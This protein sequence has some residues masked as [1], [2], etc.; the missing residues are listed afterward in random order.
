MSKLVIL[1]KDPFDVRQK[2]FSIGGVQT[3]IKNLAELARNN[4]YEVIVCE[5][6]RYGR[7]VG[8]LDYNG[9]E[10]RYMPYK[11]KRGGGLDFQSAFEIWYKQLNGKDVV[12]VVETDQQSFRS[13]AENV[14]QIQHGVAFDTPHEFIG[15]IWSR[16]L[17]LKRLRKLLSCISNARRL[18]QVPNTVCVDYNYYNWFRT[19]G[20]IR[21]NENVTVI[22]NFSTGKISEADF[23]LKMQERAERKSV[24]IVFARRFVKERGALMFAEVVKRMLAENQPIDVTFAGEGPCDA[25]IRDMLPNSDSVHFTSY[26]SVDSVDF[27]KKFDIAVVPTIFSEGTSLSLAEAMSAGCVPVCTHVGGMTNMV[28]D[29]YNGFLTAPSADSL[30]EVLCRV[31]NLP[32]NEF[33]KIAGHAYRVASQSFSRENWGGR[34]LNVLESVRKKC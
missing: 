9:I 5:W 16:T 26:E 20:S 29:S 18:H 32:Y 17:G 30:Y 31:V 15:G 22:P 8:T 23:L 21:T 13:G 4:G 34:W 11:M 24:R 28:I 7:S 27:H 10:I 3:Y 19:L 6:N 1:A 2:K 14:V 12:F 33:E 25:Q